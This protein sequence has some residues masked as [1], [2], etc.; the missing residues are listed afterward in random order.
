MSAPSQSLI[1]DYVD[2][3]G[4]T[5]RQRL[6]QTVADRGRDWFHLGQK[7]YSAAGDLLSFEGGFCGTRAF[8]GFGDE[9]AARVL[10]VKK[11]P[12]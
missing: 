10:Y 6:Y 2:E 3:R 1:R 12:F 8:I 7:V 5:V 11:A 9:D 4:H